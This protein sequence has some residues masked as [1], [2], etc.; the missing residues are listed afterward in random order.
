MPTFVDYN[1]AALPDVYFVWAEDM[2]SR[3]FDYH[4]AMDAIIERGSYGNAMAWIVNHPRKNSLAYKLGWKKVTRYPRRSAFSKAAATETKQDLVHSPVQK[5]KVISKKTTPAG[6]KE[7]RQ[8]QRRNSDSLITGSIKLMGGTKKVKPS[9]TLSEEK[10]DVKVAP[11]LAALASK[12]HSQVDLDAARMAS[13]R[14]SLQALP[15]KQDETVGTPQ[16]AS[17]LSAKNLLGEPTTKRRSTVQDVFGNAVAPSISRKNSDV[18]PSNSRKSS[19]VGGVDD[20][21]RIERISGVILLV[22]EGDM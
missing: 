14:H 2:E 15:I 4:E 7:L 8:K 6:L 18:T 9:K 19:D 11:V 3:G 12:R 22:K 5:K 20:L 21:I 10:D 13:K 16:V 17:R 1:G